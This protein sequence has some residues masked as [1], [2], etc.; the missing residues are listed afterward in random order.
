MANYVAEAYVMV[1]LHRHATHDATEEL[2]LLATNA[3]T[4]E[5]H[6]HATNYV[7][8]QELH[9][10]ATNYVSTAEAKQLQLKKPEA[11]CEC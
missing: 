11:R 6:L 2:Q 4:E 5:L 9:L 1:E 10:R 8:K 7:T 3:A